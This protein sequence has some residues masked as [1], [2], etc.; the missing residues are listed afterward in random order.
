MGQLTRDEEWCNNCYEKNK[1]IAQLKKKL[2]NLISNDK[3]VI[4]SKDLVG[5]I[6]AELV[7]HGFEDKTYISK[8]QFAINLLSKLRDGKDKE[9]EKLK[10][11]IEEWKNGDRISKFALDVFVADHN[12]ECDK[13]QEI[14]TDETGYFCECLDPIND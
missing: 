14:D 10:N 13:G 11:I 1:E 2:S 5:L 4:A 12:A 9:I 8:K 6:V 3:E 7:L